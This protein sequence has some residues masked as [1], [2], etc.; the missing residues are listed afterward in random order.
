MRAIFMK[1]PSLSQYKEVPNNQKE[2]IMKTK[3]IAV[4]ALLFVSASAFAGSPPAPIDE[5]SSLAVL[6]AALAV[7][8]LLKWKNRK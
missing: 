5:P 4:F 6:G 8:G 2:V 3:S 1:S 7:A